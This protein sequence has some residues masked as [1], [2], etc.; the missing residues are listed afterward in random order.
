M[1]RVVS[2]A[3][4]VRKRLRQDVLR[5]ARAVRYS[6]E[7]ATTGDPDAILDF[8]KACIE[9]FPDEFTHAHG[10]EIFAWHREALERAGDGPE[11]A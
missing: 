5:W 6:P 7:Q 11:A 8:L 10:R 9:R 1:S 4:A 2:I 3:P